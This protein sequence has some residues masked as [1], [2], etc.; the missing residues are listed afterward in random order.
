MHQ[1]K[2]LNILGVMV[3]LAMCWAPAPRSASATRPGQD[4]GSRRH[5]GTCQD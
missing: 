2:V 5:A 3:V 4:R 1:K